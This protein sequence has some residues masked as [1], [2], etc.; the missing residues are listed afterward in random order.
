V[1]APA[2]GK[3]SLSSEVSC[4]AAAVCLGV[5]QLGPYNSDEGSGLAGF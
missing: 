5:G 4:P 2:K 3:A 1:P